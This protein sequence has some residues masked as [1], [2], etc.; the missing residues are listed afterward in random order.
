MLTEGA[1]LLVVTLDDTA[2]TDTVYQRVQQSID[3]TLLDVRHWRQLSDFYDKT[4]QL[5]DRQFGVLEWIILFMVLLSVINS[6]NMS[7]FERQSEFG[8][9]RALGNRPRDVFRLLM[10]ESL[11]LGVSGATLGVFLGVSIALVVSAIGISMP[12]P[13]MPTSVIRPMCVSCPLSLERRG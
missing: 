9:L 11:V 12:P 5:Y 2:A 6:V 10:T 7:T 1:N 8:T 3:T 4:I 13:P